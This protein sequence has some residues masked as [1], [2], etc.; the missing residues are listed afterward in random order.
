M[1]R[2]GGGKDGQKEDGDSDTALPLSWTH[3]HPGQAASAGV[4]SRPA[5][6]SLSLLQSLLFLGLVAA[7]CLGLNL[8][9]LATY[10]VCVCCRRQDGAVQTKQRNSCCTTWTAVV[11]GLMCW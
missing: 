4:P 5:D 9:F 3:G 1:Y 11:A 7:V 6:T 8:A 2:V 10:L